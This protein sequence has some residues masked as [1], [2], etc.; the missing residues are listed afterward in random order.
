MPIKRAGEIL[1]GEFHQAIDKLRD[2]VTPILRADDHGRARSLG[3][4]FLIRLAGETFLCTAKHVIDENVNATLYIDG[5][6]KL[7]PL[8]GEFYVT[9]EHD[10]AVL[11]L[12]PEQI[13]TVSKYTSLGPDEIANDT[14]AEACRY[15]EFLG[16]PE[17]K[18]RKI[19]GENKI[20][21][22]IYALGGTPIEITP[23]RVRV[24]FNRKRNIDAR[25]RR[26][27]SAPQLPGMSGGPMF[28]VPMD[29]GAIHGTPR[30]WLI[31]VA[32][33]QPG[34]T[35][36]FGTSIAF[37]M[38]I[39]RDAWQTDLPTRLNPAHIKT[40]LSVTRTSGAGRSRPVTPEPCN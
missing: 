37:A 20:K 13:S 31:G 34:A 25:S 3:T 24:A 7:E 38:A 6:S 8:E 39:V 17:T 2:C 36:V 5:P 35:A 29:K 27:V 21:G 23:T 26:R 19:Y 11:R 28:G 15:I 4:G 22:Q 18:N 14:Q 9:A 40:T 12:T 10:V 33:D 32:T 30:A 16:Y 1:S